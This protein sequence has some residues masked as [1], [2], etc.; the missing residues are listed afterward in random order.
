MKLNQWRTY[1]VLTRQEG[2]KPT[3]LSGKQASKVSMAVFPMFAAMVIQSVPFPQRRLCLNPA[4]EYVLEK[5]R[6]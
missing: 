4:S 2:E 3:T 6:M 1:S 5:E